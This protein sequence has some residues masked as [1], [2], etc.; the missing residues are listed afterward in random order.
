MSRRTVSLREKAE[1]ATKMRDVTSR[2]EP[3]HLGPLPQA[4][5]ALWVHAHAAQGGGAERFLLAAWM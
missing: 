3:L 1:V 5:V 2:L 4:V